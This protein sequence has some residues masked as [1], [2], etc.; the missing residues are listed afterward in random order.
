MSSNCI[1][2]TKFI[3]NVLIGTYGATFSNKFPDA[4]TDDGVASFPWQT[5][6]G[7]YS[8]DLGR[9]IETQILTG[10]TL[11]VSYPPNS[12]QLRN[13]F[14]DEIKKLENEKVKEDGLARYEQRQ[15]ESRSAQP[16]CETLEYWQ[17]QVNP[18]WRKESREVREENGVKA[19]LSWHQDLAIKARELQQQAKEEEENAAKEKERERERERERDW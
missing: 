15:E 4:I 7:E 10:E 14:R 16:K 17:Y 11:Y 6:I 12:I 1:N 3:E 18:V 19:W 13:M 8:R 2:V 5:A 9:V